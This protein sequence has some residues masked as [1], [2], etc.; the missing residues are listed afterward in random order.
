MIFR[1]QECLDS[2]TG[3]TAAGL[4]VQHRQICTSKVFTMYLREVMF[5]RNL[6]C[7]MHCVKK[8]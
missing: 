6:G 3:S 7:Q 2:E 4:K 8:R 5:N 1:S